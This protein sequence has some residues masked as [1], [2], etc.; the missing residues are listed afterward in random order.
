MARE[1][2]LVLLQDRKQLFQF[3]VVDAFDVAGGLVEVAGEAGSVVGE[4]GAGA[5]NLGV[6]LGDFVSRFVGWLG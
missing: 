4:K 6:D 1:V 2:L 5:G 3:L